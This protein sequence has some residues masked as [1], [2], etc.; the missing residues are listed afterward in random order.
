MS[1][2][3]YLVVSD[4]DPGNEDFMCKREGAKMLLRVPRD[5]MV[6]LRSSA[7]Y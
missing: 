3:F 1:L 4:M 6:L 2:R 7:R 5:G